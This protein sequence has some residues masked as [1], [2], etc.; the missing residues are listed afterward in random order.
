M[1]FNPLTS[2]I[3]WFLKV[4]FR[5][6]YPSDV[7]VLFLNEW[8]MNDVVKQILVSDC[9]VEMD[10]FIQDGTK[11]DF[12]FGDLT[13]VPLSLTPQKQNKEWQFLQSVLEKSL[14]LLKPNGKFLT[15]V[16]HIWNWN[17]F[18][19]F[20]YHLITCGIISKGAGAA[21][22]QSLD[23]LE[24]YFHSLKPAVKFNRCQMFIPS[25]MESWVFYQVERNTQE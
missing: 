7:D 14:G 17:L 22:V 6:N 5:L 15:H 24:S 13:D 1:W 16:I 8:M 20:G 10:K 18:S 4:C 25:F 19:F 11:F 21:S 23:L 3:E 2:V 12:I 9:L